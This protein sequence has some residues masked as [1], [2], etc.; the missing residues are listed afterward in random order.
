MRRILTLLIL[1]LL[2]H[3]APAQTSL[4]IESG[5]SFY[6]SAGA[7][8]FIDSL[9]LMPSTPYTISDNELARNATTVNSLSTPY[10]SRVYRWSATSPAFTG[11]VGFYYRDAELN[12]LAEPGLTL[13]VHDGT[14]WTP[15]P[16]LSRDGGAN[17]I[18]TNIAGIALNEI[19]LASISGTL[20]IRW[21]RVEAWHQD[22]HNQVQWITA[23]EQNCKNYQVQKSNDGVNWHNLL[24]AVPAKNTSGPNTYRL[25][26]PETPA[27]V[28]WYR[29]QQNDL[30]GRSSYS[31]ALLV[32]VGAELFVQVYPN[33]FTAQL[34]VSV[35]NSKLQMVQVY[36]AA[37][38][39]IEQTDVKGERQHILNTIG[40]ATGTYLVT[41]TLAD[42]SRHI[43]KVFK[44]N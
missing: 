7:V 2:H 15:I 30:D 40:W 42:G 18:Q 26:D 19:T 10:I 9:V 5:G 17:Y 23:S 6:I 36:T 24:A 12:A 35:N 43:S 29:I 39:L 8:V 13:H 4:H 37:G 31:I 20:P 16:P 1:L 3:T 27:P 44:S 41:V 33:P 34:T 11:I 21:L 28:T 32:R 38:I 22:G 25:T 14:S